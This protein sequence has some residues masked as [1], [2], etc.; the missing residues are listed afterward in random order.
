MKLYWSFLQ[1][2][3]ARWRLSICSSAMPEDRKKLL[4]ELHH[5]LPSTVPACSHHQHQHPFLILPAGIIF[6]LGK[7]GGG[8]GELSLRSMESRN[9]WFCPSLAAVILREGDGAYPVC[10]GICFTL[11]GC[12]LQ[13]RKSLGISAFIT[14]GNNN[15]AICKCLEGQTLFPLAM[16]LVWVNF[17]WGRQP[18]PPPSPA[19]FPNTKKLMGENAHF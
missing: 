11:S 13:R 5:F 3:L 17:K 14:M 12:F 16:Y 19:V 4:P 18:L 2:E 9:I 7:L 10:W 1:K 15:V 6:L 8:G